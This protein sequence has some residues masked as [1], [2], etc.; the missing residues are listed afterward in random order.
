MYNSNCVDYIT[1]MIKGGGESP[2]DQGVASHRHP[3]IGMP[4]PYPGMP[5][6]MLEKRASHIPG[7]QTSE[8]CTHPISQ[9]WKLRVFYSGIPRAHYNSQYTYTC[10]HTVCLCTSQLHTRWKGFICCIILHLKLQT[11]TIF[12]FLSYYWIQSLSIKLF[13]PYSYVRTL[14]SHRI[15]RKYTFEVVLGL[16][17]FVCSSCCACFF[18]LAIFC[19]IKA[20]STVQNDDHWKI[21]HH[22]RVLLLLLIQGGCIR[23]FKNISDF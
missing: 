22:V 12:I 21:S 14:A 6:G 3:G 15:K 11:S 9:E 4:T 7:S 16:N 17:T 2:S 13:T 10:C 19:I 18:F 1:Q 8:I 23:S 20:N 5:C